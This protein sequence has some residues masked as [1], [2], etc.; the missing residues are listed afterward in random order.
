LFKGRILPLD[1]FRPIGNKVSYV[2]LPEQ[3]FSK[4]QPKGELGVLIGYTDE[5]RSYRILTNGG[6]VVETKNVQFLDYTPPARKPTNWDISIDESSILDKEEGTLETLPSN[7]SSSDK[8]EE[9]IA[10]AL[11]PEA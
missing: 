5:I 9:E 8:S 10:L 1:Y 3:S 4:L 2:I 6:K 7:D 11:V